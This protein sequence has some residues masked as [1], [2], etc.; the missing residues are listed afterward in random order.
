MR[1]KLL[2]SMKKKPQTNRPDP[3]KES[4]FN[5]LSTLLKDAGYVVRREKLKQGPG[6]KV[7]SG[8]C[9][10]LDQRLIFVDRRMDQ[11]DQ[12]LFLANKISKLNLRLKS[13]QISGLPE[14]V[15]V[16]IQIEN[17]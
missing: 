14:R 15:R 16:Q 11:D 3:Q 1:P 5:E 6:W 8:A 7:V 10:A 13:E 4:V 17:T 2:A 12:I 9:E